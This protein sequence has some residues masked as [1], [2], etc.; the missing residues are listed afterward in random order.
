MREIKI[1]NHL[2]RDAEVLFGG[3]AKKPVYTLSMADGR[4]PKNVKILKSD[5]TRQYETLSFK[6]GND[7]DLAQALIKEDP[8]IDLKRTG[9]IITGNQKVLVDEA[10]KPV[11]K[12][13]ANEVIYNPDGTIREEK[14]YVPKN[15]NILSDYPVTWTGKYLTIK[16][17][18]NKFIFAKKYQITHVNGLTFDFLFNMA[19]DLHEKQSFMLLAGGPKGNEPLVFQENGRP[20]RAFLEGR[21]KDENYLLLMHISNLE[22]KP[23]I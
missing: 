21:I 22:L 11:Y 13:T 5:L 9:L 7:E 2:K 8:E 15:Q 16:D 10:K 14:S 6:Y 4:I 1:A 18:Y 23:I 3:L 12:I 20:Y 19:K 17:T